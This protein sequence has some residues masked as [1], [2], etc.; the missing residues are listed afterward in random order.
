[1]CK[2]SGTG[3]LDSKRCQIRHRTEGDEAQ[4]AQRASGMWDGAWPPAGT[5]TE[6]GTLAIKP[7]VHAPRFRVVKGTS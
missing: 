4:R 1:M 3:G 7:Y 5:G 6:A 2:A